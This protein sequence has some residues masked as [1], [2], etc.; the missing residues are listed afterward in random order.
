M[1]SQVDAARP[2][3]PRGRPCRPLEGRARASIGLCVE[4]ARDSRSGEGV[5]VG[6][7]G[8]VGGFGG[9]VVGGEGVDVPVQ[10]GGDAGWGQVR[11]PANSAGGG[12]Q[13]VTV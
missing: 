8:V 13:G 10:G 5:D 9:G 6:L 7:D 11:E 3:A 2:V 12:M 4:L 1:L